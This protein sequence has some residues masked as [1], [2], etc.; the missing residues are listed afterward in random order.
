[1]T[2]QLGPMNRQV[3]SER[4]VP[5]GV[6]VV[7]MRRLDDICSGK[8]PTIIKI[9]VEGFEP[10]VIAGGLRTLRQSSV[11]AVLMEANCRVGRDEDRE[12]AA[13]QMAALGYAPFR[14]HGLTRRLE[15][16]DKGNRQLANVIFARS[17][18]AVLDRIRS[19]R[20]FR[21]LDYDV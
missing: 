11:L 15:P 8:S 18:E 20:R 17:A 16:V 6:D 10:K 2:S 1:M 21:V 7:A 14:Y 3:D 9:D 5:A 4:G 19:A 13:E 12:S